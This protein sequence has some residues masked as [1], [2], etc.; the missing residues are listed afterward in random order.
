MITA[1]NEAR[2]ARLAE[3]VAVDIDR[4]ELDKLKI[5][6]FHPVH[7]DVRAFLEALDRALPP[8]GLP[9]F[10]AWR[11]RCGEVKAR[12]PLL[13]EKQAAA[14]GVDLY[15]AAA[16]I[17][18]YTAAED[19]LVVSSTSR[20]NTA[21]HIALP[22]KRG[23]KSVS[24]MGM[25]SMG[26][27]LPSAVGAY[28]A[29]DRRRV[30]VLEGD[31][32][33]QLNL[34]ELET[35]TAYGIDAKLFIFD[36]DGYADITTMQERNF[37]GFYVGSN[38]ESG[39]FMPDLEGIARAYGIP[40][41]R[42]TCNEELEAAARWAMEETPGACIVDLMGSLSFDEIPKCISFV[43]QETG[44][45]VSANLENPFPFLSDEEME[46][47]AARLLGESV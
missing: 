40:F 45:R 8:S 22:R 39:L 27:A 46:R 38:R 1:F 26:F 32:S 13:A 2:F 25:G 41:R 3:V 4:A 18:R 5:Q 12:F 37:D 17:S 47:T 7:G 33:L 14:E 44:Q 28:Y 16:A 19:C 24:S 15:Q 30:V 42:V 29:G 34:Q 11:A 35:I 23:Q 36:N 6:S 9:D 21:G 10:S 43:D 31:G 20:C